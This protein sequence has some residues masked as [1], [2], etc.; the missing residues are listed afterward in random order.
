MDDWIGMF[1]GVIR[2]GRKPLCARMPSPTG[3]TLP[4]LSM[5]AA[6]GPEDMVILITAL[7]QILASVSFAA[8][9]YMTQVYH[10]TQPPQQV[11]ALSES[12]T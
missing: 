10:I 6:Y 3:H 2:G 1:L 11:L 9:Q 5:L 12:L 7:S 8:F 4:H